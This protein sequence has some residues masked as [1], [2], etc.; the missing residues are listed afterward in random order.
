MLCVNFLPLDVVVMLLA[1][2][3]SFDI[4]WRPAAD[5]IWWLLRHLI[6]A[7][8]KLEVSHRK[9]MVACICHLIFPPQHIIFQKILCCAPCP[10]HNIFWKK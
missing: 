1:F 4:C 8:L 5:L 10:Q 7:G 6:Y 3:L 2:M 9:D